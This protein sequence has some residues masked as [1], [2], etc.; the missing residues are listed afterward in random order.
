M[1]WFEIGLS[2]GLVHA[3]AALAFIASWRL[4]GFPDLTLE[5]AVPLAA[6][7]YAVLMT[8]GCSLGVSMLVAVLC[9]M[10][11]GACTGLLHTRFGVNP[12]LSGI[13]VVAVAYSVTLRVLGGSNRGLL[14]VPTLFT[15]VR[16]MTGLSD[17]AA[18]LL[19]LLGLLLL[20]LLLLL[21]LA[22]TRVGLRLRAVGCNPSFATSLG[23]NVTV[24]TACGVA[25]LNG[26][27]GFTG[28]LFA[29]QSGFADIGI[30]QGQLV[31]ALAAMA[32]GEALLPQRFMPYYVFVLISAPVGSVL[33]HLTLA[34]VVSLGVPATDL[35]LATALMVLLV[36][37]MRAR[38]NAPITATSTG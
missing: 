12:F 25:C 5:G 7:V 32:I 16:R 6:S 1:S 34:F 21:W 28:V 27:A 38:A 13:L 14:S 17:T 10:V 31:I 30:G 9:A 23:C 26:L 3:W 15:A 11:A 18:Q 33:Y 19:L 20:A 35:K 22:Q 2:V 29:M 24:Y 36:V 8:S 37:A 4:L